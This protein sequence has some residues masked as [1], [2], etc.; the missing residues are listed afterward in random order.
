MIIWNA[1]PGRGRMKPPHRLYV[2][3]R[4]GRTA[5]PC[6][7]VCKSWAPRRAAAAARPPRPAS[8]LNPGGGTHRPRSVHV[9]VCIYIPAPGILTPRGAGA[10]KLRPPRSS[11]GKWRARPPPPPLPPPSSPRTSPDVGGSAQHAP[12]SLHRFTYVCG[13][14]GATSGRRRGTLS[15][16]NWG[17]RTGAPIPLTGAPST[18]DSPL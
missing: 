16:C 2:T 12:T 3:S 18:S 15:T 4:A 17:T 7:A 10:C 11:L 5:A 14:G 9:C 13:G 8:H 1:A 6:Q